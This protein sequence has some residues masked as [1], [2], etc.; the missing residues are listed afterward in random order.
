MASLRPPLL[1]I[2][3]LDTVP[4]RETFVVEHQQCALP[5]V[6][7]VSACAALAWTLE[8]LKASCGDV[9]WFSLAQLTLTLTQTLILTRSLSMLPHPHHGLLNNYYSDTRFNTQAQEYK[10][11]TAYNIKKV[12]FGEYISNLQE[13]NEKSLD[14]YLAVQN[15]KSL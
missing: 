8:S 15:I 10:L 11:G 12:Q 1:A 4:S 9:I 6:M 3:R 14:T 7:P 5:V 2:T 13:Q